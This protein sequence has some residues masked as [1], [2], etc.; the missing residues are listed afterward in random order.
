EL[1]QGQYSVLYYHQPSVS[2]QPENVNGWSFNMQQNMGDKWALFGRANGSNKGATGVKN[3]YALGVAMLNPLHRNAADAIIAG[4]AYN[5]L[6]KKAFGY[7]AGMHDS[8]MAME[9]QWIWGIG[10]WITLT[11]D[12]QFYPKAG[13]TNGTREVTVV[14]LRTTIML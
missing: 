7:P 12:L 10:N 13:L 6:S 11:P 8:E 2:A 3:S 4:V 14:G 9:L 5:D 1:G